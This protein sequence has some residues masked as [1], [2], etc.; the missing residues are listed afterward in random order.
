MD[1][2]EFILFIDIWGRILRAISTASREI[3]SPQLD[4]TVASRL[5]CC[6]ISE[7]QVLRGSWDSIKQTASALASAWHRTVDFKPKARRSI[8]G[9]FNDDMINTPEQAFKVNVFFKTVDTA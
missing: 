9:A 7:L 5:L 3:Q 1:S 2:Y 4:L 8:A 6:P